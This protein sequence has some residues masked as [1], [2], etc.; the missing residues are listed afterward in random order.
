MALQRGGE[1]VHPPNCVQFQFLHV[2]NNSCPVIPLD[3]GHQDE[4]RHLRG[5]GFYV[6][7]TN[8]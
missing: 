2:L 7:M 1:S 6:I 8:S 5:L 4:W 3:S